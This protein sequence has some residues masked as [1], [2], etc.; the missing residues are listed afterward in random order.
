VGVIRRISRLQCLVVNVQISVFDLKI[1]GLSPRSAHLSR[2]SLYEAGCRF[3][4]GFL[5]QISSERQYNQP[6]LLLRPDILVAQKYQ[7]NWLNYC[8]P[9]V[10]AILHS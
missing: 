7:I 6:R 9:A 3:V 4:E 2:R 8:F 5:A 1:G 10:L